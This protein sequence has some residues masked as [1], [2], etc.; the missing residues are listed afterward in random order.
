[1]HIALYGRI[2]KK[3]SFSEK[4]GKRDPAEPLIIQAS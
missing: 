4:I 2:N 1:M 3:M